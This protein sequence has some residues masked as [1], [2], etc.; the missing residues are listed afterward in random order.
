M[1]V[2]SRST[3]TTGVLG[4]VCTWTSTAPF[5]PFI[6]ETIYRNLRGAGMPESVHLCDFPTADDRTR[7]ALDDVVAYAEKIERGSSPPVDPPKE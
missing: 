2:K 5:T 6:S 3:R 7:R 4:G 1:A